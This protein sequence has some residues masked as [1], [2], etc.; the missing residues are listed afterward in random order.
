MSDVS[1]FRC[2]PMLGGVGVPYLGRARSKCGGSRWN[3]FS[4]SFRTK[5]YF[6]FCFHFRF[7]LPVLWPMSDH[8]GSVRSRSGVVENVTAAVE[9]SFVVVTQALLSCNRL[10]QSISRFPAAILDFRRVSD[11]V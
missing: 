4:S 10:I 6:H 5:G 3:R 11:R 1:G 7:P 2:W 9:I 8:V